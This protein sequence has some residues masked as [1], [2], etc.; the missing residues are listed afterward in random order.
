MKKII[1][2][3]FGVLALFFSA[4]N[5]NEEIY[6]QLDSMQ[7]PFSKQFSYTLTDDDYNTM[8]SLALA[9]AENADDS[10]KANELGSNHYFTDSIKPADYV[11]DF[12]ANKFLAL[13]SGSAIS[14]GY[15]F[16]YKYQIPDNMIFESGDTAD[17]GNPGDYSALVTDTV[18]NPQEGMKALV[19]Y[20]GQTI[21]GSDTSYETD[22]ALYVYDGSAWARPSDAFELTYADYE[23][24]PG[25]IASY[26]NFSS[27]NTPEFY[28]PIFLKNK[29]PYAVK[30]DAFEIVYKYYLGKASAFYYD[31][32]QFDGSD[33]FNIEQKSDQFINAG[34]GWVFD[35]TVKYEMSN[36][37]YQIIVDWVNNNDT[38][39]AYMSSY[40]NTE[41]YFGASS[42]YGNFDMRVSKRQ[43]NDPNGY[44]TG[45]SDDEAL[46]A[47]WARIPQAIQIFLEGKFP[48]AVPF[49]NG[50]PVYYIITFSTYEPERHKYSIKFLCTDT[51]TF[52]YQ[53]GPEQVQ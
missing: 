29:Y 18:Q 31:Y 49:V 3:I 25:S 44:L 42:Y 51:G 34:Q 20:T 9:K 7:A 21:N 6:K 2:L 41:Y 19:S 10:A 22:Y 11:P 47:I 37:D 12:L 48:N 16:S 38:L 14:V 15:N 33:W 24:M 46:T 52:E 36:D 43:A 28:L 30:G 4:C 50:V 53:E 13:D 26:H 45:L 8:K 23:E 40:G 39:N 35:P 27:S 17:A 1:Y 5:P 32:W